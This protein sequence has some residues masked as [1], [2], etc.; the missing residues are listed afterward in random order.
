MSKSPKFELETLSPEAPV[1][2]RVAKAAIRWELACR[3]IDGEH[4]NKEIDEH[5][6]AFLELRRIT[7]QLIPQ[8]P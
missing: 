7:S 6:D 5:A 8:E 2:A 1:E 4:G 3:K